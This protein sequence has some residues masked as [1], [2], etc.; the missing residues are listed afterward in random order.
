MTRTARCS[1]T[2][3]GFFL[4]KVAWLGVL[5]LGVL[6]GSTDHLV[7]QSSVQPAAYAPPVFTAPS[8][9]PATAYPAP[10]TYPAATARPAASTG[11]VAIEPR[12]TPAA[13]PKQGGFSQFLDRPST[14]GE[15]ET[16]VEVKIEGNKKISENRILNLVTTRKGRPFK[17]SQVGTDV[18]KLNRSGMFSSIEPSYRMV[19]GGRVVI[20]K[21][22][23]RPM[24]GH[25]KFVGNDKVKKS[26][27]QKECGLKVGDPADPFAVEDARRALEYY[28]RDHGFALARISI[29]E[30]SKPGDDGV[31]FV[32]HEGPK[33]RILW[34]KF[35]GNT[36]A[37]DSRLRTQIESKQG[38]L[39]LFKGEFDWKKLEA[40]KDTLT[41]YY[42]SLGFF[43]ARVGASVKFNKANEWATVTF[44]IDEGD[45]YQIND[46]SVDG[47]KKF[48][49]AKLLEEFKLGEGDYFNQSKMNS[50][51]RS[52]KN[53]YGRFG[54]VFA[55]VKAEPRFLEEPGKIDL[56][57][58]VTEGGRFRAGRI[59][60]IIKGDNPHTKL[61][62]VMDRISISP[63]DV[64]NTDEL[65]A[66]ERRLKSCQL[67]EV[68][69]AMGDMP[70]ISFSPSEAIDQD[71]WERQQIESAPKG[72]QVAQPPANP[73]QFRGQSP[74]S[75]PDPRPP[76]WI[77][78]G[79]SREGGVQ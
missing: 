41:A 52:M 20:F 24:F 75:P 2:R 58:H 39:W 57:L 13:E 28:Y 44:V 3:T 32:I 38:I 49:D 11:A 70:K 67:F 68:N 34:T 17:M 69:P 46:I 30:G 35:I 1:A 9:Q 18:R 50:D 71:E 19:D 61:T 29:R 12:R 8:I 73:N 53:Q 55:D 74:T 48:T 23:E 36:I 33:Q 26:H 76:V 14:T 25:I 5:C 79:I 51:V 64:L 10:A 78:S 47:N 37:T 54:Y 16:V 22:T 59:D 60:P 45:Q 77:E 27:L 21:V 7:A 4:G 66:S 65:R 15:G 42:R 31:T 6:L 40:D 56:V 72:P 63:G 43:R 62:T